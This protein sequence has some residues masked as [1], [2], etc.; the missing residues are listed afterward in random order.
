[1]TQ[2]FPK[3][4]CAVFIAIL[5]AMVILCRYT[6]GPPLWEMSHQVILDMPAST[7]PDGLYTKI[8]TIFYEYTC[9]EYFVL[10]LLTMSPFVCRERFWYYILSILL[11]TFVKF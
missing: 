1:M 6:Y 2:L 5:C 10:A 4:R 8:L 9:D 11:S 3:L 7:S